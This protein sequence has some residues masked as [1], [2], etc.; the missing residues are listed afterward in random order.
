MKATDGGTIVGT[1]LEDFDDSRMYS[2]TYLNQFGDDIAEEMF[3]PIVSNSDPRIHDGCYYGGGAE[4]G[5]SPCVP[6]VGFTPEQQ[7]S[8]AN[9]VVRDDIVRGLKRKGSKTEMLENGQEVKVGQIVMFVDLNHSWFAKD[10]MASLASLFATSSITNLGDNKEETLFGRIK[11]LANNFVDGVL[12]VF[13]LK[14]DRVEIK[15]ELCVDGVCIDANDLRE[16]LDRNNVQGSAP[17]PDP[18]PTPEPEQTEPEVGEE[19]NTGDGE[20]PPTEETPVTDPTPP[21]EDTPVTPPVEEPEPTPEPTP[22]SEQPEQIESP[23]TEE[24]P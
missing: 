7:L 1:A 11:N 8:T 6:L 21:P 23:V 14:A 18:E 17:S 13:K 15:E 24:T 19:G 2:D 12:S 9:E 5:D 10:Q 4:T 3:E 16:L 22:E 20:Q